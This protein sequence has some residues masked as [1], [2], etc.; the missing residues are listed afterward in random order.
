MW[1][2]MRCVSRA[3]LL[4]TLL[5]AGGCH[6]RQRGEVEP[7]ADITLDVLSRRSERPKKSMTPPKLDSFTPWA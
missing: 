2:P 6:P 5:A 3:L 7:D 4:L 1:P